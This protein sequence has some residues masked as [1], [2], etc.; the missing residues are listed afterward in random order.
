MQPHDYSRRKHP[1]GPAYHYHH[2]IED[3]NA[4]CAC[5]RRQPVHGIFQ[6]NI[7]PRIECVVER[8]NIEFGPPRLRHPEFI[9]QRCIPEDV[10]PYKK[11]S[12]L[13][14]RACRRCS[15]DAWAWCKTCG[16]RLCADCIMAE[17]ERDPEEDGV[18]RVRHRGEELRVGLETSV[19]RWKEFVREGGGS[20]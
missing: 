6:C 20:E 15:K 17:C 1:D 13:N 16:H 7:C 8:T 12:K 9:K 10:S 5:D 18:E 11:Y 19:E 4:T 3:P 2:F 14:V